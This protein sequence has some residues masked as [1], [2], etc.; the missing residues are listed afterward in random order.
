MKT[1]AGTRRVPR[2]GGAPPAGRKRASAVFAAAALVAAIAV[3]SAA[4]AAPA[5]PGAE[6]VVATFP[7]GEFCAFPIEVAFLDGTMLHADGS[8][9]F[10]TG[11]LSV[12]VTNR[13]TG[14]AAT[15]NASGPT[16]ADGTLTGTALIGQPAS[17]NVGPAF[18]IIKR[19]RVTFTANNTIKT[20]TGSQIDIC[21]ALT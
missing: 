2:S 1:H 9:L 15:F 20:I 6:P 14:V 17:R 7:A 10:S 16:F 13:N 12:T 4:T 21:A 3:P 19:G 5:V 18:L 11:P 8:R